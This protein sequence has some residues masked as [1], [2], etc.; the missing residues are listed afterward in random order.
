MS[1][2]VIDIAT[3]R[4]I[5]KPRVVGGY[6]RHALRRTIRLLLRALSEILKEI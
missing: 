4:S 5:T 2:A 6:V 1:A 3:L